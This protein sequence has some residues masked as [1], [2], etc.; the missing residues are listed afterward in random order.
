MATWSQSK[1]NS[2]LKPARVTVIL[3]GVESS[4][5]NFSA[6]SK[7]PYSL[8]VCWKSSYAAPIVAKN[9]LLSRYR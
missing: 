2:A 9:P 3:S 6:E 7:D 4:L 8:T 5:A 1:C